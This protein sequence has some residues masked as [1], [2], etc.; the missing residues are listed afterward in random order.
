[1]ECLKALKYRVV[2]ARKQDDFF[3]HDQCSMICIPES[4]KEIEPI[5]RL[6]SELRA[7]Y[8]KDEIYF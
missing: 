4:D 2:T 7:S 6:V 1:M 3:G 5:D 8:T